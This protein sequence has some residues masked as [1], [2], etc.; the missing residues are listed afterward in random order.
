MELE[1]LKDLID[2]TISTKERFL[3]NQFCENTA[4]CPN[5]HAQT[6]LLLSEQDLW[7]SV[8]KGL[9]FMGKSLDG[10]AESPGQSEVSNLEISLFVN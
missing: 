6:V 8:P 7:G 5:I 3:L 9:N 4:N 1:D 10:Q 2:F